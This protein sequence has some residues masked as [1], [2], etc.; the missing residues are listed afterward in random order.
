MQSSAEA[1]ADSSAT[2]PLLSAQLRP[3]ASPF[4]TLKRT[5]N[6]RKRQIEA[7]S[8]VSVW[9]YGYP[10]VKLFEAWHI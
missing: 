7:A 6:L 3:T 4:L 10:P 9:L 5:Q 8:T 1:R 2:Q